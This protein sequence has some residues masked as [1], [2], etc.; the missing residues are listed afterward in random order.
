MWVSQWSN[1]YDY[2]DMIGEAWRLLD[3]ADL[4]VTYNGDHFD[5]KR[6]N[7][8]FLLLGL[9]KPSPFISLDLY[10]VVKKN[11]RFAS[12]KLG[13]M[14]ETLGLG[15]KLNHMGHEMWVNVMAGDRDAQKLMADYCIQDV[16]LTEALH[17]R[18]EGWVIGPNVNLFTGSSDFCPSCG[19]NSLSKRG[20]RYTQT[21][22]YQ[23][24]QC[25]ICS[26]W[27]QGTRR[28][29]GSDVKAI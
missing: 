8:E 13:Y 10:K 25:G 5:I 29:G 20:F 15:S 16:L 17:D 3:E 27:S 21:G 23:R 22:T 26:K 2:P 19:Q 4:V 14:T 11:F 28:I 18:L 24:Y 12:H 1:G 6:L 9:P 7:A